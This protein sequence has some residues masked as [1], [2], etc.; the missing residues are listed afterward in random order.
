MLIPNATNG[1]YILFTNGSPYLVPGG[2]YYLG[3][4]NTNSVAVNY[5]VE[6][7]FHLVTNSPYAFTMAATKVTGTNAQLNGMAT[8]GGRFPGTAWFQWGINTNYGG[9]TPPI[10]VGVGTNVVYVTAQIS[11]IP[12]IPFHC[13]LVVSNVSTVTYGFD[14]ILDEANVAVWGANYVGQANVPFSLGNVVAIAGAYDHSMA[15]RN[16]GTPVAWGDN[17]FGQ[18]T[19]PTNLNYSVVAVAGGQYYS[20][21]LRTNGTVYAWGGNILAQTNVP[22]GLSNVAAIAGGT[23]SSLALKTNGMVVAWGPN[24][25]GLT[26]VPAGLSN[27]VAVSGGTYHNVALKN[28]GTVVVWGDNS[29]GQTNVPPD[30]TNVV[31]IAAGGL[32]TLALKM[33]G[34]VVAWGDDS[35][36]QTNVPPGLRNVVAIA[37]GGFSSTILERDGTMLS[38]GDNSAGQTTL[39]FGLTN[40]VAIAAGNLQTMALTPLN[41]YSTNVSHAVLIGGAAQTNTIFPNAIVYYQVNVPADATAATN[42]LWYTQNGNL[43]VWWTTNVPTTIDTTNDVLLF[44][45]AFSGSVTFQTNTT[46]ILVPGATYYLG[47]HNTN[48]STVTYGIEVDFQEPGTSTNMLALPAQP[49][50]NAGAGILMTVTNT[51]TDT[52]TNATLA[53]TL[54]TTPATSAVISTNGIITW[55]PPLNATN[56]NFNFT[57]MVTDGT[58]SATNQFNVLVVMVPAFSGAVSMTNGISLQWLAPTNE[59]FRVQ[60]ATNLMVPINWTLLPGTITSTNGIFNFTDTNS[61]LV[62]KFYELLLLP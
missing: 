48:A 16:D 26:N 9:L 4:Q 24:F 61:P 56:Q 12:N 17:S 28:D 40:A 50:I 33:D 47:V 14:Q 34:T 41:V 46:P 13:R 58:L 11:M 32:H 49:N 23:L 19:V 25:L 38:W 55:T 59:Q 3:L 53:Y 57:T 39:P 30:L 10:N 22:A 7:D 37:A 5:G 52:D 21:V 51:A 62:M 44:D 29:S 1:T 36:G 27:V 60:Y 2:T 18:S 6:V 42:I 45:N 54:Q 15:L 31:A 35:S 43:D 8:P 20:L